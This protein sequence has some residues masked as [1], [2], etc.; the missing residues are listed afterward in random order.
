[1]RFDVVIIGGGMAGTAA[2]VKLQAAGKNCCIV[3]GGL[4]L[5]E[6]S[7]SEFIRLGGIFLPGDYAVGG[8]L[9]DSVLSAVHTECLGSTPLEAEAFILATGR[10]VSRGLISTMDGIFEPVFGADVRFEP[11]RD[12]WYDDDFYAPQPFENFGVLTDG[13]FRV[14]V[15]GRAVENLYAVGEILADC[16]DPFESVEKVC[17]RLM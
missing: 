7:R 6:T 8:D 1:M 9:T 4:S 17:R 14:L 16:K 10:F 3:G 15:S 13:D 5:H 12:S 2:G 11:D